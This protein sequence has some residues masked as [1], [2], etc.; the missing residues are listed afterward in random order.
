MT[1]NYDKCMKKKLAITQ[2]PLVFA[3]TKC[4]M[5]FNKIRVTLGT[6]QS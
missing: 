6:C 3:L 5:N 2:A 1:D 4:T